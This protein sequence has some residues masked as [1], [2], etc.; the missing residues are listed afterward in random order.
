MAISESDLQIPVGEGAFVSAILSVPSAGHPGA[1]VVLAHGAGND[2]HAAFLKYF[3]HALAGAGHPV[4]RF[5]FLYRERKRNAPDRLPML[6]AVWQA[7]WAAADGL[8]EF[9]GVP[10]VAAGKSMGGRIAT[11]LAADG[12]LSPDGL[13]LLGYPLHPVGRPDRLRDA[14]LYRLAAPLLFFAGT[15][16]SLCHLDLLRGV[17]GRVEAPWELEVVTGGDHSFKVPKRQ[18]VEQ[19]TVYAAM[20]IRAVSWLQGFNPLPR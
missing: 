6:A 5:N 11:Q 2:M 16:D 7:A 13:L 14:H 17:L 15:R 1:G 20:A 8:L 19:E 9:R 18:G 4:L 10:R 12:S 3:A